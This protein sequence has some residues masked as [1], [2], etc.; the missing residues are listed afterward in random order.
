MACSDM[1][2]PIMLDTFLGSLIQY[3]PPTAQVPIHHPPPPPPN[4]PNMPKCQGFVF[5]CREDTAAHVTT[6]QTNRFS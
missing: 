1:R 4:P 6:W 5:E 3:P 2:G